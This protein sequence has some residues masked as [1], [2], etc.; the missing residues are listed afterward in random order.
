MKQYLIIFSLFILIQG[1]L[2]PTNAWG[3]SVHEE[4]VAKATEKLPENW[5]SWLEAHLPELKKG[6]IFPDQNKDDDPNEPPR[7]YD[8]SDIPHLDINVSSSSENYSLGVVS[9]AALNTSNKLIDAIG[10]HDGNAVIHL[11]GSLSHYLSDASQ[12][13]HATSNFD[14][15]LTGNSGIHSRFE[16][17]LPDRYWDDIWSQIKVSDPTYIPN[18][19]NAT[20]NAI[21]TGLNVVPLLLEADNK[22]K[23]S[24]DY[25]A[26]FYNETSGILIERI[27]MAIQLTLNAWYSAIV[28]AD[29]L[30]MDLSIMTFTT[31]E[32]SLVSSLTSSNESPLSLIFLFPALLVVLKKKRVIQ[33]P[34]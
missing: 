10:T 7:H 31:S 34:N 33:R 21:S 32:K 12:P 27:E 4:V 16:T 14:G 8:D 23:E 3:Y 2:I 30:E 28:D 15:Q 9:W 19:Y 18:I 22:A 25:W 24:S 5:K 17:I 1:M 26:T 29:A 11:M 20:K 6:S 13:F